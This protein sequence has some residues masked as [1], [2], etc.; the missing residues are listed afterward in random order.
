[1][2]NNL[3]NKEELQFKKVSQEDAVAEIIKFWDKS[4]MCEMNSTHTI[5]VEA[6][7]SP[8]LTKTYIFDKIKELNL[9]NTLQSSGES[10]GTTENLYLHSGSLTPPPAS[11]TDTP[12]SLPKV[13]HLQCLIYGPSNYLIIQ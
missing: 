13:I 1:M 8:T 9:C 3:L 12:I 5:F 6:T 2:K 7:E 10:C 4:A 11:L